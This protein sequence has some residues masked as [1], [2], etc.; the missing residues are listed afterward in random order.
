MLGMAGG[1]ELDAV[2]L[3]PDEPPQP[4]KEKAARPTIIQDKRFIGPP[5]LGFQE[6]CK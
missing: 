3:L 4:G 2:E 6:R 5:L 1:G